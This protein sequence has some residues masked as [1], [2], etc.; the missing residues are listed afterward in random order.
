MV[1]ADDETHARRLAARAYGIATSHRM[2]EEVKVVPWDY[3]QYVLATP[4]QATDDY[5]VE[6]E[7]A[8]V[9]PAEAIRSAHP[10]YNR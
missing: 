2:G 8:I 9:H 7:A 6:G 1:R 10:G 4:T 3:R 5:A